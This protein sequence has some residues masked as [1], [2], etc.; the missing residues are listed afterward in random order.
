MAHTLEETGRA[1]KK[2]KKPSTRK[3]ALATGLIA[4]L[5]V[6]ALATLLYYQDKTPPKIEIKE[7]KVDE[8]LSLLAKITDYES[9]VEGAYVL[10]HFPD[11]G[12]VLNQTLVPLN[13]THFLLPP[14]SLNEEGNYLV[15]I[16]ARDSKGN[17]AKSSFT[18]SRFDNPRIEWI[19]AL[20]SFPY[21]SLNASISDLGGVSKVILSL[22]GKNYTLS[23]LQVDE[24]G[25]GI[26][27]IKTEAHPSTKS[28]GYILFALD[29]F[30]RSSKISSN[31]TLSSRDSFI[32]WALSKGYDAQ[33]ASRFFDDFWTVRDLFN[34]ND[35]TTL[36]NIL[37]IASLNASPTPKNL[38]YQILRN[39]EDDNEVSLKKDSIRAALSLLNDLEIYGLNKV[40]TLTFLSNYS[41]AIGQSRLPKHGKSLL[42]NVIRAGE[43]YPSLLDFS[44]IIIKVDYK[45]TYVDNKVPI[46]IG[47]WSYLDR[48][49]SKDMLYSYGREIQNGSIVYVAKTDIP[50]AAWMLCEHLKRTPYHLKHPEVFEA[51]N[52]K[53]QQNALDILPYYSPYSDELWKEI[54]LPHWEYF[55]SSTPQAGNLSKRLTILPWY[56]SSL[57]KEWIGNKNDRK[58]A[59]MFLFQLP[60]K[61]ED[62]NYTEDRLNPNA[63]VYRGAEAIKYFVRNLER[64]YRTAFKDYPHGVRLVPY[65]NCY[66]AWITD[67]W[68]HGLKNTAEQFLGKNIISYEGYPNLIDLYVERNP[69]APN[70]HFVKNYPY[71]RILLYTW[72]VLLGV[73]EQSTHPIEPF[74]RA[75]G[76]PYSLGSYYEHF[77]STSINYVCTDDSVFY[78]FP[79]KVLAPLREGKF[80]KFLVLPGNG[81]SPIAS[82]LDGLVQDLYDGWTYKEKDVGRVAKYIEVYV[83]LLNQKVILVKAGLEG[84]IKG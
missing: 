14:V 11:T 71:Y 52:A 79:D 72:G 16:V 54:L 8:Y 41:V 83:P 60:Q 28:L 27:G 1:V 51:L 25:R 62:L 64:G 7:K 19:K 4:L 43:E 66:I 38:A 36:E 37:R 55:W 33:L 57:L 23:P 78:G 42:L 12:K 50:I 32:S 31:V 29:R 80:G 46:C 2:A 3:V 48:V 84:E 81:F 44:P 58:I 74:I 22:E 77:A 56:N 39:I 13:Q 18:A 76:I 82:G 10:I 47:N 73:E 30:N 59:L 65:P 53:M 21:L 70:T 6:L 34:A 26:Y 20:Y 40:E 15:T 24:K 61:I 49:P 68:L 75:V 5:S 67:R 45:C 35:T 17:E 9:K 63:V 69:D